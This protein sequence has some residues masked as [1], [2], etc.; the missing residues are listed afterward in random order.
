MAQPSRLCKSQAV[1][2][3]RACHILC[4]TP[5]AQGKFLRSWHPWRFAGLFGAELRGLHSQGDLGNEKRGSYLRKLEPITDMI[6][7]ESYYYLDRTW[8]SL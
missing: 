6:D 3:R 1:I 7:V 4:E 8:D 2:R 5:V